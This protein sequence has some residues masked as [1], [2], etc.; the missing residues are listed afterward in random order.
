MSL[1]DIETENRRLLVEFVLKNW[2]DWKAIIMFIAT[3]LDS[4]SNYAR[5]E[6]ESLGELAYEKWNDGTNYEESLA[7]ADVRIVD[8]MR[9]EMEELISIGV[10]IGEVADYIGERF[11]AQRVHDLS[12]IMVTERTR[13]EAE[14]VLERGDRYIYHCVHDSRTCEDCRMR[15]GQVFLSTDADFGVNCP[16]MHPWCRCWLTNE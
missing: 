16:P 4:G 3:L 7:Q 1:N 13:I 8:N 14:Q 10:A 6:I 12:R 5:E 15:D 11:Y 9:K 2:P